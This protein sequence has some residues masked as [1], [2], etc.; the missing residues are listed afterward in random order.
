[1]MNDRAQLQESRIRAWARGQ[2]RAYH[3]WLRLIEWMGYGRMMRRAM[4]DLPHAP[5]AILDV[6]TGTGAAAR[7]AAEAHPA[8]QVVALDLSAEFLAE[9]RRAGDA[10]RIWFVQASAAALPVRSD[11][12]DLVTSFGVLCHTAD[13]G[14][15]VREMRRILRPGGHALLWTRG[16]G[17]SGQLLRLVFPLTSGGAR[18]FLYSRLELR[19]MFEAAGFVEVSVRTVAHGLLVR[20]KV[21]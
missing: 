17:P 6:G 16:K 14:A 18:F 19:G 15:V 10:T 4:A 2:A 20:G 1:M 21:V 8:A 11:A 13:A 7:A 3:V 12:F 5:R 9:A